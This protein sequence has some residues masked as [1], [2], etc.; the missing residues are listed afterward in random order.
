[1]CRA[2]QTSGCLAPVQIEAV[3]KV[4]SGPLNSNGKSL[5]LGGPLIGSEIGQWDKDP[6]VGWG[7]SYLGLGVDGVVGSYESLATDGFRYLF[8]WPDPGPTWKPSD[9][10]FDRDSQRMGMMQALYDSG[11]PDLRKFKGAGGKLLIVQGLSDNSVLPRATIDYYETVERTMGG[12]KETQDFCRLFLLPGVGHGSG[13]VGADT[14][15]YLSAL[16]AW[17]ENGR[18]PD[19]LIAAHLKNEKLIEKPQFPLEQSQIQ[20]TRPVYPYPT[21][22]KYQGYGDSNDAASF[23]PVQ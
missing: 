8:F 14:I 9:F 20:F 6:R 22:A 16:E 18:A 7:F 21:R 19:R 23:G 15:D 5:T 4:Y 1:M 3:K 2:G 10:D 11:N 13:G 17:V 12:Q